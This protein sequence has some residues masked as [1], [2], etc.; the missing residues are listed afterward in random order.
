MAKVLLIKTS[1]TEHSARGSISTKAL[2]LWA[3]AYQEQ[4]PDDEITWMNLNTDPV[5][6]EVLTSENFNTY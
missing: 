4:H 6:S 1:M 5:G 3:K 2:E